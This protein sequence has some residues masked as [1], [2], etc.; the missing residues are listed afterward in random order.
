MWWWPKCVFFP[1]QRVRESS[2]EFL[3]IYYRRRTTTTA[4]TAASDSS[5]FPV[6]TP[7]TPPS[8]SY[9]NGLNSICICGIISP[10]IP[11]ACNTTTNTFLS[12][13]R[14]NFSVGDRLHSTP[15]PP[16][17]LEIFIISNRR[18][19]GGK[20]LSRSLLLP[21]PPPPLHMSVHK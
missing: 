15:H 2:L 8:P 6:A 21:T 11:L 14:K 17:I 7:A 18:K 12:E 19:R 9:R 13:R 20:L 16:T 4:A 10:A 1:T 5:P 3:A